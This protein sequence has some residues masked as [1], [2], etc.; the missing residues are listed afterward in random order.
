MIMKN[1]FGKE[2]AICISFMFFFFVVSFATFACRHERT[3]ER[4]NTMV[5][6]T[7]S[8]DMNVENVMPTSFKIEKDSMLGRSDILSKLKIKFKDGFECGNIYKNSENGYVITDVPKFKFE[9]DTKIFIKAQA[10]STTPILTSLSI[11]GRQ[12][13]IADTIYAGKTQK[14]K[15]PVDAVCSPNDAKIDFMELDAEKNWVLQ[16]GENTLTIKVKKES[17]EKTYTVKITQDENASSGISLIE[18]SIGRY[19]REGEKIKEKMGFAVPFSSSELSFPVV[20]KANV[21]GARITYEPELQDNKIVFENS[22]PPK[23]DNFT[24][25]F[26][27]TVEKNGEV[28][29]Y[30]VRVC[31]ITQ[32]LIYAGTNNG[33]DSISEADQ[34]RILSGEKDL[35]F[36]VYEPLQLQ[37]ATNV[38][39]Y[40]SFKINDVEV[41]KNVRPENFIS[42]VLKV[43]TLNKGEK[44]DINIKVDAC[45]VIWDNSSQEGY[46]EDTN[47]TFE[48]EFSFSVTR[49]TEAADVPVYSLYVTGKDILYQNPQMLAKISGNNRDEVETGEPCTIKV[50]SYQ[51][52]ETAK[53]DGR[54]ANVE[55]KQANGT[56]FWEVLQTNITGFTSTPKDVD[57]ELTPKD[58]ENYKVTTLHLKLKYKEPPKIALQYYEINGITMYSLPESFKQ[59]LANNT[60][61]TLK[62]EGSAINL[63]IAAGEKLEKAKVNDQEIPMSDMKEVTTYGGAKMWSFN[64]S[65]LLSGNTQKEIK[66]ELIP[67]NKGLYSTNILIFTA[68]GTTEKEKMMPTFVEIAGYTN[69]TETF[70]KKLTNIAS[71]PDFSMKGDKANLVIQLKG[72]EGEFLCDKVTINGEEVEKE[73]ASQDQYF[74]PVFQLKKNIEGID[75]TGKDVTIVFKGK[76]GVADDITWKFKLKSGGKAP[77]LPRSDIERF[78]IN[79]Y[80][81]K[82]GFNAFYLFQ[83]EFSKG[84]TDDDVE[85]IFEFYGNKAKIRLETFN[86]ANRIKNMAFTLDGGNAEIIELKNDNGI[87]VAECEFT[88]NDRNEHSVE[89]LVNPT[90]EVLANY[91]PLK[92]TFK[93][94]SLDDKPSPNYIFA[95]DSQVRANGYRENLKKEIVSLVVQLDGKE[96]VM[97]KVEIGEKDGVLQNCEITKHENELASY[98]SAGTDVLLENTEKLYIIKVTPKDKVKYATVECKFYLK[99]TKM[100][101][102]NAEFMLND[103]HKPQVASLLTWKNSTLKSRYY[104]DYGVT[105]IKLIAKTKSPHSTVKYQFIDALTNVAIGGTTYDLTS[106]NKGNHTSQEISL[107]EDKCTKVKVW[108]VS[109]NGTTDD[110]NGVWYREFNEV[111]TFWSAETVP[112]GE[113]FSRN[114]VNDKIEVNKTDIKGGKIHLAIIVWNENEGHSVL[115]DGLGAECVPFKKITQLPNKKQEMWQGSVDVSSLNSGE[116]KDIYVKINKKGILCINHKITIKIK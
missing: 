90:N 4:Q 19:K 53:I 74:Y 54:D 20:A 18:L 55:K 15:V 36:T 43:V 3:Q 59:G 22:N 93:L 42:S 45:S 39:K 37:F 56:Y 25:N 70:M 95:L 13:T 102:N 51:E 115:S 84:L 2:N 99:G 48:E 79:N 5:E 11:D 112:T 87:M 12:M 44:K 30:E 92:Y 47:F 100:D 94:K 17:L 16:K 35:N 71:P 46:V 75:T 91:S 110:V 7:I 86:Q 78:I 80:G 103:K 28:A 89:V 107:Y 23:D 52:I 49:S 101:D 9:K 72:Y 31:K 76:T 69:I 83:D 64:H 62:V 106:D 85:P 82:Q 88:M 6:I 32:A 98:Y 114:K 1:L 97:E 8:H 34:N 40:K 27:I 65:V 38:A 63:K 24:K 81:D 116:S 58:K 111:P 57:I 61:P 29:T 77:N 96:D 113:D 14:N 67:E 41:E 108:V 10:K 109:K 68:I 104:N 105:K 66:V 33:I 50:V 26:T 60:K 73:L 21:E